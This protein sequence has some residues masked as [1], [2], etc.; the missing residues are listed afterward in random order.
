MGMSLI[1]LQNLLDEQSL[2]DCHADAKVAGNNLRMSHFKI[3]KVE[4]TGV[5][6]CR[7]WCTGDGSGPTMSGEH[8]HSNNWTNLHYNTFD[9]DCGVHG[10]NDYV[11]F[12]SVYDALTMANHHHLCKNKLISTP[13]FFGGLS[14]NVTD[15][16]IDEGAKFELI[17]DASG[18]DRMSCA[19]FSG[20][21]AP[22]AGDGDGADINFSFDVR[23]GVNVDCD[24]YDTI[25]YHQGWLV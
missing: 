16:Q 15:G 10:W 21:L 23:D 9:E 12:I 24:N 1:A 20:E 14:I 4:T 6:V 22:W 5:K 8:Q 2:G 25:I 18:D 13:D 19:W 17:T 7:P 3:D 11:F